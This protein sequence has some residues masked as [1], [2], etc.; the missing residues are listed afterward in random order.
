[1]VREMLLA[2]A[3]PWVLA[4]AGAGLTRRA[5]AQL[6]RRMERILGPLESDR[7]RRLG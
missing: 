3:Q 7:V 6:V 4:T 1:M 2:L 5:V